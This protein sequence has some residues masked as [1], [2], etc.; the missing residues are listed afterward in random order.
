[1]LMLGHMKCDGQ[2]AQNPVGA[3][4]LNERAGS[5]GSGDGA[6]TATNLLASVSPGSATGWRPSNGC[7]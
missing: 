3:R 2:I 5:A 1:M 6:E 7:G 4:R